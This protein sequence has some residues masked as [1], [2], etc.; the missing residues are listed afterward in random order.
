MLPELQGRCYTQKR[1]ITI[2]AGAV[3]FC[4]NETGQAVVHCSNTACLRMLLMKKL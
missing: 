4:R 3:C 2:D 1:D